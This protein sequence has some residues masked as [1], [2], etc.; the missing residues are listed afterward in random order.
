M[1]K[2]I[3]CCLV[4]LLG[5]CSSTP[6]NPLEGTL[7]E[8]IEGNDYSVLI[9][10]ESSPVRSYHGTYLG[11]ADFMEVGAR[12]LEKAKTVFDPNDYYITEGQKL[13]PSYLG[14]L[15]RRESTD[16]P[17]GLNPPSGSNFKT[18]DGDVSVLDAVVVADVVETDFYQGSTSDPQLAGMALAIVLNQTLTQADGTQ[19]DIT[20]ARLYEY[21]SDMG[22]KLERFIRTLT[23]LE[24]LPVYITLYST[25]S[26][27]DALPGHYLGEGYFDGRS[28]QFQSNTEVWTLFPSSDAS[29]LDAITDAAFLSFKSKIVDFIPEAIGIIGEGRYVDHKLDYLKLTLTIQAKTY[30]EVFALVQY[31]ASLLEGFEQ[32]NY[33]I[34][35]K[36]NSISETLALIQRNENGEISLIQ[37]YK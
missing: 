3:L 6:Q 35:V 34:I 2:I 7:I 19:V 26:I 10:F 33:A 25:Q 36:I 20:D 11:K 28:G 22:R 15:V 5:A 32:G 29:A 1:K 31:V 14:Q 4:V 27:D 8:S 12:L 9:P 37:P 30:T 13:T 23:D 16:N 24:D 21:G 17:Y 18:G